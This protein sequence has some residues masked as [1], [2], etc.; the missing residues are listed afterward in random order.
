LSA[1]ISAW[2]TRPS[3]ENAAIQP[4]ALPAEI[5]SLDEASGCLPGGAYTT[6]RTYQG[7]KVLMLGEQVKR[8]EGSARL[9][10]KALHVDEP[11]LRLALR[12]VIAA[13]RSAEASPS[14]ELRLRLTLDL[15]SQPGDLYITVEALE[16]PAPADYRRGVSVV[17]TKL[18]R[19]LPEAKLTRF[20]ARSRPV[21]RSLPEGVN[22]AVMVNAQ[23]ELLEGLTS[24]FFAVQQGAIYTAEKGVLAGITRA[25][26]LESAR[27]AGIPVHLE[28][29]RL[30][31]LEAC[32]EAFITSSSRGVLPVCRVDALPIGAGKPGPLTRRLGRVYERLISERVEFI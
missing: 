12:T 9:L 17:T 13:H 6:L 15:E 10:G 19:L 23:G 7:E 30:A 2:V 28:P 18:E 26:A 3:A 16:T 4:V 24:N 21:R 25:L 1:A 29:V 22:E 14:G 32:Q 8:L 20:I 5:A 27:R 31:E 11:G